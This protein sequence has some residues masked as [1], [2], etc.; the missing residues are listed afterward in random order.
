MMA[1][2]IS[3]DFEKSNLALPCGFASSACQYCMASV[4]G[5]RT[6]K[7]SGTHSVTFYEIISGDLLRFWNGGGQKVQRTL[8][9]AGLIVLVMGLTWPWLGRIPLGRLPGD[10]MINRPGFK[11]YIPVTSMVVVSILL[12]I[13]ARIFKK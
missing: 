9:Y 11:V 10:I 6:E 5:K 7:D 1:L 2:Q 4:A 13:L 3:A 8:I 12:T